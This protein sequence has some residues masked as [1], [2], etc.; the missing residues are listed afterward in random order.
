MHIDKGS[1]Q[2]AI[3]PNDAHR[4]VRPD[5]H[6]HHHHL[7]LLLLSG[8]AYLTCL[9]ILIFLGDLPAP[10]FE[11]GVAGACCRRSANLPLTAT[12]LHHLS[13]TAL[14]C[15]LLLLSLLLQPHVIQFYFVFNCCLR[16]HLHLPWRSRRHVRLGTQAHVLAEIC[17]L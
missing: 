12:S 16:C 15:R 7:L 8:T 1:S 2:H 5:W 9:I 11:N 6:P 10:F 14:L 13:H 3:R 4:P 17:I